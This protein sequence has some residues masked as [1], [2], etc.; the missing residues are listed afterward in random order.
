MA[1]TMTY[2]SLLD[3]A[4][5]YLD[6]G[7]VNDP[8]LY[9]QLPRLVAMAE[10]RISRDLK[11]QG[12]ERFVTTSVAAGTYIL[13]KPERWRETICLQLSVGT[14]VYPLY[15]RTR[16]FIFARYPDQSVTGQ[17]QFYSDMGYSVW[18]IGPIPDATYPIEVNY[19]ELLQPLD[20][21]NQ[22]NWLTEYAPNLMLYGVLL[23][24]M[25]FLKNDPRIAVWT[26]MY[27][28]ASASL[29]VEDLRKSSGE[30]TARKG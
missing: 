13:Q 28:E 2:S 14:N 18:Q 17:P 7:S 26:Q 23:E 21:T 29:M 24:A 5:N 16:E 10:K 4:R 9:A 11:P 8:S 30:T 1:Y 12:F 20:A 25:P 19:Y 22:T 27:K 6:R 3:D 15:L